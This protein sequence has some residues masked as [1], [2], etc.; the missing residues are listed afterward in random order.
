MV[1]LWGWETREM[2]LLKEESGQSLVVVAAFMGVA[3]LG[4]LAFAVDAGSL[5]RAKRMAQ[6]AADSAALAAAE[7]LTYGNTSNE[8]SAANAVAK[9]NGFDTTL[10]KNPASVT[11]TTPAS[12]TFSGSTYVQATVSQPIQTIFLGAFD[13]KSTMPVSATSIAGG[14]QVSQTCVCLEG[15]SGQA[16]SVSNGSTLNAPGCGIVNNSSGSNAI[17]VTGGST[18]S[19]STLGTVSSSWNNSS[20]INSGGSIASSTDVVQGIT[21]KCSPTMPTAP[22]YSSCASDPG[23]SYGTFTWGP[24]S[25]SGVVCYKALTVGANGSTVTLNPGTYVITTGA[26][27]FESGANGHSNLGGNG[28]FFYLTGTAS[29]VIDSGANV[30]LVAGGAKESGG[31]TA[32]TVG[33]YDGIVVYQAASDTAG[34]TIAGGSSAY[35]NGALYAPSAAVTVNNGSGANISVGLAVSSLTVTGGATLNA[36][37]ETNEGS[38]SVGSAKLVQ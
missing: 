25:A 2:K 28:V 1:R 3:A 34:M 21:S 22:T 13:G 11:L 18:L 14:A 15:S 32:P 38:L 4:F 8:Q 26:L 20:N 5:F 9:L 24:S 6:A 29:L 33:S 36:Q 31:T 23:G 16:L 7:E 27:H 17:S 19:A 37:I 35:L 30:N 10:S 12:G